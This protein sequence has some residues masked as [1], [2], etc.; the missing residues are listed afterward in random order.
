MRV[1]AG[2]VRTSHWPCRHE[3]RCQSANETIIG[4]R[5]IAFEAALNVDTTA[6][7]LEEPLG[8]T[9]SGRR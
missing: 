2:A 3:R 1:P 7:L 9:M 4:W 6:G 8:T 5:A